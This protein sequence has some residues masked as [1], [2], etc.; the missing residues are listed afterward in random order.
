VFNQSPCF[1]SQALKDGK[2]LLKDGGAGPAMVRFEKALMLAKVSGRERGCTHWVVDA[3]CN[4]GHCCRGLDGGAWEG[5]CLMAQ[6]ARRAAAAAPCV[7]SSRQTAASTPAS[8]MCAPL[9]PPDPSSIHPPQ[10]PQATGDKVKERRATRGLAACARM[11]GQLRQVRV[12]GS[13]YICVSERG[14]TQQWLAVHR[15]TQ[16]GH[17]AALCMYVCVPG[18]QRQA[19]PCDNA[20]MVCT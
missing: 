10:P 16:R 2:R 18:L 20:A 11:Q 8:V 19:L 12:C 4:R 13:V 14:A 9:P 17:P 1:A 7:P 3:R 6:C 15:H 5:T